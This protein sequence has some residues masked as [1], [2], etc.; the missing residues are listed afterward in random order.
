[1]QGSSFALAPHHVF[2]RV[3]DGRHAVDH[4]PKALLEVTHEQC[5]LSTPDPLDCCSGDRPS[6]CCCHR[7]RCLTLRY[8]YSTLCLLIRLLPLLAQ[9][10]RTEDL[11]LAYVPTLSLSLSHTHTHTHIHNMMYIYLHPSSRSGVVPSN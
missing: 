8:M 1:M 4:F 10:K 2:G 7:R 5:R 3:D 11:E 9:I 6:G